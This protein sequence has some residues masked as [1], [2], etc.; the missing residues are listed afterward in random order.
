MEKF[1]VESGRE[2][3]DTPIIILCGGKGIILP[4]GQS[5]RTN[6][7]LI[8]VKGKPLI[9]WVMASYAL[10]GATEFLLAVGFQRILL[11]EVLMSLGARVSG[12]KENLYEI[13]E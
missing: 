8:P 12:E 10:H 11:H 7:A 13:I 4:G 5:E 3:E 6:K 9:Y 2:F 1:L